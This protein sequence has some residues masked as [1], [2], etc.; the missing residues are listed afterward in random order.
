MEGLDAPRQ[1]LCKGQV[2]VHLRVG[3]C[4]VQVDDLMLGPDAVDSAEPLNEAHR[5]P[6]QVVVD[7]PG[8]IL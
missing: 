8:A 4:V 6:V 1:P 7:H 2:R 5:V 3:P